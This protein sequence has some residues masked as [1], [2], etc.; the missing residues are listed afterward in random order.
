MC[1]LFIFYNLRPDQIDFVVPWILPHQFKKIII[2]LHVVEKKNALTP[3]Y[4]FMKIKMK[5]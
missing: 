2:S 4:L 1:N 5:K 3:Y